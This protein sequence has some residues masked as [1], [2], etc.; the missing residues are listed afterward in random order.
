M[1]GASAKKIFFAKSQHVLK[2]STH[3][4][5]ETD[6]CSVDRSVLSTE[7]NEIHPTGISN[8]DKFGIS[9]LGPCCA[10]RCVPEDTAYVA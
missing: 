4:G 6:C 5:N 7:Q 3:L 10:Y 8:F 2:F 1:M 9:S